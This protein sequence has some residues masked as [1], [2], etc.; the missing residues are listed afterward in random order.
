MERRVEGQGGH[1]SR[2]PSGEFSAAIEGDRELISR[3][4]VFQEELLDAPAP[5]PAPAQAPVPAPSSDAETEAELFAKSASIDQL[6]NLMRSVS[7]R[8]ES[9]TDNDELAVSFRPAD[10]SRESP[11]ADAAPLQD[12]YNEAMALA[13]KVVNLIRKYDQKQ[14][15]SQRSL[16]ALFSLLGAD[17]PR[18]RSNSR[19]SR[20]ERQ[21]RQGQSYLRTDGWI[22]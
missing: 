18:F 21:V 9:L 15:E 4:N 1:L 5:A 11:K 6:L 20:D 17:L 7:A 22:R 16:S 8:G 14:G 13:P 12:R 10:Q 2:Q 19:A 3:F